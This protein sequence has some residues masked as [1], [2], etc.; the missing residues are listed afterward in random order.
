VAGVTALQVSAIKGYMGIAIMLLN[1]GAEV[2]AQA[3][4][5]H[6]RTALEWAAEH[7]RIDMV[8]LLLNAGV[9]IS[10]S[11]DVQYRRALELVAK[12]GHNTVKQLIE[13][14][15]ESGRE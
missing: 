1:A 4:I 13:I 15:Y 2:D 12:N 7:G 8:Q 9:R 3:A 5:L 6:G 11:R 14:R 10:G